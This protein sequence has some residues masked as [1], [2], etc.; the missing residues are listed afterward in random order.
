MIEVGYG[1][2]EVDAGDDLAMVRRRKAVKTKTAMRQIILQLPRD[3]VARV[4]AA[5]DRARKAAP[6]FLLSRAD[7]LRSLLIDALDRAEAKAQG[8]P[9]SPGG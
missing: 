4:E 6:G 9:P 5:R 7:V 8:K 3:V 2:A 1:S